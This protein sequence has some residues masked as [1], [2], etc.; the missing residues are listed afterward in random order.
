MLG[1]TTLC[2]SNLYIYHKH[3]IHIVLS[4]IKYFKEKWHFKIMNNLF[5]LFFTNINLKAVIL[6]ITYFFMIYDINLKF[7][8]LSIAIWRK[9]N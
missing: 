3:K 5:K 8:L 4:W 1:K 9:I 7:S 6:M 2:K